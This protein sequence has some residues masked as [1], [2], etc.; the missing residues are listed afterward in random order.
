[1]RGAMRLLRLRGS[2]QFE[3]PRSEKI[4]RIFKAAIQMRLFILNSCTSA[5]FHCLEVDLYKDEHEFVPSKTATRASLFFT[6]DFSFAAGT[7]LGQL[8]AASFARPAPVPPPDGPVPRRDAAGAAGLRLA[9]QALR[10]H[11]RG[12]GAA[13]AAG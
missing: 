9:G 4:F 11:D 5:D 6:G 8:A 7:D 10:G 2:K 1:M 3:N 12:A 13:D